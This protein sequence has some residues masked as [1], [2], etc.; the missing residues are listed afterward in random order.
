[1]ESPFDFLVFFAPSLHKYYFD[2]YQFGPGSGNAQGKYHKEGFLGHLDDFV[3]QAM[4]GN[5]TISIQSPRFSTTIH[6]KYF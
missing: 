3:H 5:N 1:M 2:T 4:P 6:S